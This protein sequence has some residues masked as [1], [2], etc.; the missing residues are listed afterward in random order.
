MKGKSEDWSG[1]PSSKSLFHA[2][3]NCGLPIGNLL[4]QLFGNIY[5]N[6]FDHWVK[7]ELGIKYYSRYVDDFILIHNSKE[8][9]QSV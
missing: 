5:M 1:L 2:Q 6:E 7:R 3:H 4:S 8:Y 9:L